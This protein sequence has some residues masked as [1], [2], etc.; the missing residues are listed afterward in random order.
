MLTGNSDKHNKWVKISNKFAA[1]EQC[2]NKRF[3]GGK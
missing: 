2:V 1:G 3:N